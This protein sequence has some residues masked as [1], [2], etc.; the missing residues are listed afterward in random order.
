MT[1]PEATEVDAE[2]DIENK[3]IVDLKQNIADIV[4][5]A[6]YNLTTA[7]EKDM[8]SIEQSDSE[9][10]GNIATHVDDMK[11]SDEFVVNED[12]INVEFLTDSSGG[13]SMAYIGIFCGVGGLLVLLVLGIIFFAR[14]AKK[15]GTWKVERV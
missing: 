9:F 11:Q 12:K 1:Y 6:F 13:L 10:E 8:K 7:K 4:G 14:G 5:E 3:G 2:N 15:R